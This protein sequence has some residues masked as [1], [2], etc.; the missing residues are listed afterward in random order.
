MGKPAAAAG[1]RADQADGGQR[2]PLAHCF[3]RGLYFLDSQIGSGSEW[4]VTVGP[5][6]EHQAHGLPPSASII[7]TFETLLVNRSETFAT[8]RRHFVA[9]G[10]I[11]GMRRRAAIYK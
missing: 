10:S 8:A 6:V 3:S 4:E 11:A 2:E 7:M 9:D 5:Q 1:V